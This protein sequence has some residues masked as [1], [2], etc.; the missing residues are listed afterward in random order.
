MPTYQRMGELLLAKGLITRDQHQRATEAQARSNRRFGE[1]IVALGFAEEGAITRCL[2]E[3][4]DLPIA[5]LDSLS[6]TSEALKLV[7]SLFA[8]TKLFLPVCLENQVLSAVI[9]DPIDLQLTDDIARSTGYRLQ[10]AIAP[11]SALSDK[12]AQSYDLML[13]RPKEPLV[14]E[15]DAAPAK[16]KRRTKIDPQADRRELLEALTS[17][18]PH[19]KFAA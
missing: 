9:Y 18:A 8:V 11:P 3:Q 5:D 2:A 12:I 13:T 17:S 16:R 7:S 19:L 15:G 4:Y 14:L 10:L 6:P 1:V